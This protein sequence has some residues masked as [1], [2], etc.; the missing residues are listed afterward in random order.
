MAGVTAQLELIGRPGAPDAPQPVLRAGHQ[1]HRPAGGVAGRAPGRAGRPGHDRHRAGR[2][3]R[4][5]GARRAWSRPAPA[6]A[7]AAC[8]PPTWASRRAARRLLGYASFSLG[9]AVRAAAAPPAGRDRRHDHAAV[10]RARGRA[11]PAPAPPHPH[12]A[13]EHG[14][15]PGR[16]RALR[17]AAPRRRGEP[18]APRRST[19]GRSGGSSMVVGLDGAMVDLLESQYAAGPDRPRFA[20]VPELGAP[21]ARSPTDAVDAVGGVRRRSTSATAPSCST[22]ATPG[23]ATASTPCWTRPSGSATRRVFL[24]VGGGARWLE[25]EADVRGAR[26]SRNVVFRGYVPKDD[27]PAVMAG[28]HLALITLD[29]R[30]LGVMSPSK[31]HANLAAGLPVLYVGPAGQQR[32]RGHR[33]PR[34]GAQPAGGRRGR[35]AWPRCATS[36]ATPTCAHAGPAGLRGVLLRRGHPAGLRPA[37]RGLS[38]QTGGRPGRTP[39]PARR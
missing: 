26:A 30:S 12:R 27:T 22:S 14:L 21:G 5:P 34:R 2:L 35:R 24:F 38:A 6:C 20:V 29:E 3:P 7:S 17:R 23:S 1:P 28:A 13:V 4:G 11:A 15:L 37:A 36:A 25:L 31:L 32:R 39:R 33:A 10:R 16:G 18:R 9:S 8:G 19:A